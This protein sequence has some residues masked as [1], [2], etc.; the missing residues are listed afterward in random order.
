MKDPVGRLLSAMARECTCDH[1]MAAHSDIGCMVQLWIRE[2]RST[3]FCPCDAK[4]HGNWRPVVE[5]L[6]RASGVCG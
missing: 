4:S 3:R 2:G 1:P 5:R 6:E